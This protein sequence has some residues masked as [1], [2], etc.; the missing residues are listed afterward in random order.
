M[1]SV[2]RYFAQPKTRVLAVTQEQQGAYYFTQEAVDTWYEAN[3]EKIEKLGSIYII[4]GT[5]SGATFLDVMLGNNGATELGGSGPTPTMSQRKT[6]VDLGKEIH[7]GNAAESRLFVLRL[8]QEYS[9]AAASG[10]G[11]VGYVVVENNVQDLQ[12][13]TGR[14][15]VRVART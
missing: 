8:V 14:F 10:G 15:T 3:A 7:I 9:P 12:G 5:E 6:L 2:G 13:N 11:Q 1:S 4:P